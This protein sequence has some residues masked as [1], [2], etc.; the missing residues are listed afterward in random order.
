MEQERKELFEL[1]V[2]RSRLAHKTRFA[3][4]LFS[5]ADICLLLERIINKLIDHSFCDRLF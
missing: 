3:Y 1:T 5:C 2:W 4:F